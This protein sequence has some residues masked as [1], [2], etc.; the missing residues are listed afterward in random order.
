MARVARA[1]ARRDAEPRHPAGAVAGHQHRERCALGTRRG[2]VRRGSAPLVAPWACVRRARSSGR[3]SWRRRSTSS[4]TSVK[5]VATAIRSTSSER[6]ARRAVLPAVRGGDRGG[7]ARSVMSAYNSVDGSPATQNR[8]LLTDVLR[9]DGAFSGFVI[10]DAAATGGATVLHTPRRAPPP[11]RQHALDAGLDV[12][13]QSSWPQHR[14]YLEAFRRGLIADSVIDAAVSRVLRAK[15]ELG[16][17]E[18]PVRRRRQRGVLERQRRASR[19]GARGGARVDRAAEERRRR[20]A[21]R[22]AIAIDRRDRRRRRRSA[23]RRL[24]RA[25]QST[26]VDSRRHSRARSAPAASC[27]TRPGPGA[28]RASTSSCRGRSSRRPTA[29]NGARTARRVF[30]QQQARRARRASC[31]PI[32]RVDFG[33]TLNSPG[34]GIPFDWYS[35]RWTGRSPSRR[36]ACGASASRATTA[37]GC[38]STDKL[39]IDNWRKQS[40][41]SAARRRDARAGQHARRSARVLRE[42]RQ[43]ARQTRLGR[44]RARRLARR[45]S[46][47]PSRSR[48]E[49]RRDR[50]RRHRGRRVPRS[51]V[52]RACPAIR[53]S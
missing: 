50:R 32:A 39:V 16:L 15:F 21:A 31:A 4:P 46:T 14:P 17:F 7:H 34:R 10:S 51:R 11:R 25:G 8:A 52:A 35:V 33:W 20:A 53:K 48:G 43:R 13:F 24:Q 36:A 19:A 29:A 37:I 3:A 30:R 22:D 5:A 38:T 6:A 41:G 9:R 26:G 1:I 40:Y 18:Q 45:R 42:H 28:S 49:R 23:A 47:A 12:V 44:R 2:D 27:A